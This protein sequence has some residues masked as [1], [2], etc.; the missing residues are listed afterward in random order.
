MERVEELNARIASRF[1]A[2]SVPE[3]TF[4]PRPTSTKFV[5]FP[6]LDAVPP[7]RVPI[8]S[9]P[10]VNFL[11]GTYAPFSGYEIQVESDLRNIGYAIQ[12]DYR[13]VYV[14]SS[15]SDMYVSRIPKEPTRQTHPLLFTHVVSSHQFPKFK[16]Q[17]FNN[18]RLR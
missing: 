18:V 13:S 17:I 3:V 16:E 5:L 15:D 6:M 10:A 12:K 9:R 7:S 2:S 11:P 1:R 4:S 14:P 8:H